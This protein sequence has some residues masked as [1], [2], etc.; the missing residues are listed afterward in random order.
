MAK[1][2]TVTDENPYSTGYI[3]ELEDNKQLL[4]RDKLVYDYAVSRDKTHTV[5]CGENIYDIAFR[6]FG[7]AKLWFLIADANNIFNPFELTA[8]EDIVIPDIDKFKLQFI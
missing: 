8:G 2:L 1:Q 4:K 7:N 3:V 6:H 5:G